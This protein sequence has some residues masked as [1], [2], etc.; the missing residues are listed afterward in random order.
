MKTGFHIQHVLDDGV[1]IWI[2]TSGSSVECWVCVKVKVAVIGL[3]DL[4]CIANYHHVWFNNGLLFPRNICGKCP[5]VTV[6]VQ[7]PRAHSIAV[8]CVTLLPPCLLLT[9]F[10]TQRFLYPTLP[11]CHSS[12]LDGS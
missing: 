5:A 9:G 1:G 2:S 6:T 8:L 7:A 4:S 10:P 12:F 3:Y 11:T